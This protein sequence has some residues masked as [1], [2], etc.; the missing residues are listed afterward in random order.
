VKIGPQKNIPWISGNFTEGRFWDL[1]MVVHL[2]AG[3][4][5]GLFFELIQLNFIPAFITV[6]V[7]AIVWETVETKYFGVKEVLENQII[8]II[9]ALAGFG[10]AFAVAVPLRPMLTVPA[11]VG[12]VAILAFMEYKGWRNHRRRQ[13]SHK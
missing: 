7:V 12:V 5:A 11:L 4:G 1:W 8:D 9:I 2:L 3:I 10:V 6:L 13:A